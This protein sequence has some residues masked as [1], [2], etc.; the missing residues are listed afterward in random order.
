M[1]CGAQAHFQISGVSGHAGEPELFLFGRDGTIRFSGGRLHGGR[2]SDKAMAEIPLP[3]DERKGWRVEEEFIGAI[4]GTESVRL[5]T[6][7]DGVR[8]ME[9]TEAVARSMAEGRSVPVPIS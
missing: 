2:R 8:Y 5:T 4:R 7:D 9:F 1:A 3:P 6:F